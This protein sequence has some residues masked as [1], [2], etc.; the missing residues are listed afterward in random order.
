[1]AGMAAVVM[2]DC[3]LCFHGPLAG[4]F[5][6][7]GALTLNLVSIDFSGDAPAPAKMGTEPICI[8][9]L[10]QTQTLPQT[11]NGNRPLVFRCAEHYTQ[12][13][14]FGQWRVN[15]VK[16]ALNGH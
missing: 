6:G 7:A 14:C 13:L 10:P 11:L 8:L 4:V 5:A 2:R 12:I 9:T 15:T 3:K 1:M 16:L